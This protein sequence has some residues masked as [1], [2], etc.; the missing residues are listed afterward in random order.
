MAEAAITPGTPAPA[1]EPGWRRILPALA[2]F[3]LVPAVP[4]LRVLF[5]MEQTI[6]LVAPGIAVLALLAWWQGGRAWFAVTWVALSA[7]MLTRPVAGVTGY[8]ELSRGWAV[9]L[10]AMFGIM[11][12]AQPG[13]RFFPRGLGT[14]AATFVGALTVILASSISPARVQRTLADE[15]DRR[16]AAATANWDATRQSRE[17]QEFAQKSPSVAKLWEEVEE[18][19]QMIGERSL[20]LFPALLALE[21]LAGLALAWG[22]FHR[23]SRARVGPPLAPLREFR[24]GDQLVWGLLLGLAVV[25]IPSLAALRGLGMNL[26]LFFGAL[27]VLRGLGV[28]TWFLAERRLAM[29]ML[30]VL[31]FVAWPLF[32]L[33][34]LGVGLGDTWIDWRSRARPI[35]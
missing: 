27:Y 29:A 33:L 12:L 35:T 31:A 24:F 1:R 9:L 13:R 3:L 18:D 34:S 25:V 16:L 19:W 22:L 8:D 6:L 28:L 30:Y 11:G 21:S 14:V 4:Y 7:W 26:L 17:W 15:I 20:P 5:P 10:A 2:L 23:L 32:G